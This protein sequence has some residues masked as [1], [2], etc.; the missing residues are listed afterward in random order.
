MVML[1]HTE[2]I[3][4][5]ST[6]AHEMGHAFH[7]ELSKSQSPIYQDY[8]ISVAEV[9]STLFE[10][11]AFEEMLGKL[12]EKEKVIALH[13][14][15][16]DDVSTIFRQIA[17]FNFEL[18][19]HKTIREKGSIPKEEIAKMLNKHMKSYLGPI[20]KLTDNDGYFFVKWSHIRNF[21]YVYSYAYGQ[22]ISKALYAR[23]KEDK[24]FLSKIEQFLSAGGSKSPEQIFKDIG[25]DVSKPEFFEA[26]LKQVEADIKLLEQLAKKAKLI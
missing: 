7:S 21:F 11:F 25:I 22:I 17:C 19:L 12:S 6:M 14:Q 1:N 23:Y 13:N 2:D 3:Q 26:G 5:V 20:M 9:A 10:N 18:E 24:S 16:N 15:I 4:A 8:T